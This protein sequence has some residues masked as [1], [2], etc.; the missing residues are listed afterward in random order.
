ME[1]SLK[2]KFERINKKILSIAS[3][4]LWRLEVF[5]FIQLYIHFQQQPEGSACTL[6]IS[7]LSIINALVLRTLPE[8]CCT[9]LIKG[10]FQT[11][12]L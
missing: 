9:K 11:C 2:L 7:V 8:P 4:Y 1:P 3:G 5:N 10:L 6:H 12:V